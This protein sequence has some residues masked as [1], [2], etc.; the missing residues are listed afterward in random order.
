MAHLCSRSFHAR[1]FPLKGLQQLILDL[2]QTYRRL[3]LNFD[4]ESRI[5][6]TLYIFFDHI[7]P[8]K[9]CY[10]FDSLTKVTEGSTPVYTIFVGIDVPQDFAGVN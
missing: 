5:S 2:A 3:A 6:K 1:F 4:L 7:K 8:D 9:R 10:V